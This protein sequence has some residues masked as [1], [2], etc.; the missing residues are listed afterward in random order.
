M[1]GNSKR[2]AK[3]IR[4]E[5]RCFSSVNLQLNFVQQDLWIGEI[6]FTVNDISEKKELLI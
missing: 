3:M 1:W 2:F 6:L 4:Q 5:N